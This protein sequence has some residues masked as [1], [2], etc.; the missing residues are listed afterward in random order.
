MKIADKRCVIV[1][2]AHISRERADQS[3]RGGL[4]WLADEQSHA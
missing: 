4:L 3:T 2:G 1:D